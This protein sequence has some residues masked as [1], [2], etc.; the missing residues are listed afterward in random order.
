MAET[1]LRTNARALRLGMLIPALMM[2]AGIVLLILEWRGFS[3]STVVRLVGVAL[4]SLGAIITIALALQIRQPRLAYEDGHLLVRLAAGGPVRVPVEVVECFLLG[5]SPGFLPGKRHER[6]ETR[7][8]VIRLAERAE[9][10]A[11][12]EV[13]PA[14]GKWCDGYITIRGTWC[15]PLD[16]EVVNR[17]NARLA[18]VSASPKSA[19]ET[20]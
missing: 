5:Q 3:Q 8:V 15:E 20:R 18:E 10:W 6:L 9:E 17:L 7:S 11:S 12:R 16:V 2:L 4:L 14:L 13:K 1:W 19:Q